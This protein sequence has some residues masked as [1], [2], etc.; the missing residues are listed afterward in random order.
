[1]MNST[2]E[3][4][5]FLAGNDAPY[6]KMKNQIQNNL[7]PNTKNLQPSKI[8]SINVKVVAGQNSGATHFCFIGMRLVCDECCLPLSLYGENFIE[9]Y[10]EGRA[11]ALRCLCDLH[12]EEFELEATA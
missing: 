8:P 6:T 5:A 7:K 2:N 9:S 10:D 4:R 12:A 3:R 1:M 11:N